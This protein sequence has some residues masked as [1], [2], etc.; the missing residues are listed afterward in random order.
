MW[1]DS[2]GASRQTQVGKGIRP[3]LSFVTQTVCEATEVKWDT[4]VGEGKVMLTA[5]VKSSLC[6]FECD[7]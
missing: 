7:L 2:G 6:D 1:G 4:A 3:L 5:L